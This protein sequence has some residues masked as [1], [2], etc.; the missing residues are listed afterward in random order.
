MR[1]TAASPRL[2]RQPPHTR[3]GL[4]AVTP[5][6]AAASPTTIVTTSPIDG[7]DHLLGPF[8]PVGAARPADDDHLSGGTAH[9][10][11][12][13]GIATIR[14]VLELNPNGVVI[15]DAQGRVLVHNEMALTLLATHA[16]D[17][18]HGRFPHR[19]DAEDPF[20]LELRDASG[21]PRIVDVDS[22]TIAWGD[23]VAHVVS[24]REA[25]EHPEQVSEDS[26]FL[27]D[28]L[29]GLPG[30]ELFLNRL[31]ESRRG[32]S[33][34]R[35]RDVA[36]AVLDLD[37]FREV[38]DTY[39]H[40]VGDRVLQ[41]VAN[42]LTSVVRPC[43]FVARLGDDDFA[44]LLHL[45]DDD[46]ATAYEQVAAR[47]IEALTRPCEVDGKTVHCAP[48]IGIALPIVGEDDGATL[49]AAQHA[50]ITGRTRDTDDTTPG[51]STPDSAED[52]WFR[53]SRN[54]PVAVEEGQLFLHYQPVFDLTDAELCGLEALVRWEHPDDGL[55]APNE[56]I[57]I[58]DESGAIISLGEWVLAEVADQ[59]A[60]WRTR[61]PDARIPQVSINVTARQLLHPRFR[62]HALDELARRGVAPT[63]IRFEITEKA[64]VERTSRMSEVL[65]QLSE[66]GFAIDLDDFGTGLSSL[67]HLQE[68][69]ISS[70]KIDR[71][72][73]SRLVEDEKSQ[74]MVQA[75]I[76]VAKTFDLTVVAEGIET[77]DQKACL[78][79]WGC[80]QAQ[81]YLLA[82]PLTPVE[83]SRFFV[84]D[85]GTG[86]IDRAHGLLKRGITAGGP[87][88]SAT[89]H[90]GGGSSFCQTYRSW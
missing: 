7:L 33:A 4:R 77:A 42:R 48:S 58:A 63:A 82:R 61:R 1:N 41:I 72:Y 78:Y 21:R 3:G 80:D 85:A 39:G 44:L 51:R 81:G 74:V 16:D 35:S 30:R 6:E 87:L 19:F 71:S 12:A 89:A 88:A 75:I 83:A 2:R 79:R 57:R 84:R 32:S 20:T 25:T 53:I 23:R 45:G 62:D 37:R 49:A 46:D 36:V 14:D 40:L 8:E 70:I 66:D 69:P 5:I 52:D 60:E 10:E 38:N 26:P 43:D 18:A 67:T 31:F 13:D 86:P 15:V 50:L 65:Q 9:T 27:H 68:F 29:T 34:N 59:I 24:L 47:V 73:I 90:P 76:S 56:F 28:S 22:K 55:I 17:L 54:L 64:L 11:S